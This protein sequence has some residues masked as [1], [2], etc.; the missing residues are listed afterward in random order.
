MD[1]EDANSGRYNTKKLIVENSTFW[2]LNKE[3]IS[4]YGGDS[5]AATQGPIININHCT[6]DSIGTDGTSV[7]KFEHVHV[8]EVL[9]SIISNSNFYSESISLYGSNSEISYSDT[10]KVGSFNLVNGAVAS[11]QILGEDPLYQPGPSGYYMLS[12]NSPLLG[13]AKDWK[14]MGDLRWDPTLTGVD[15]DGNKTIP[16]SFEL[17]QNYPNP[18]NPTTR[19]GFQLITGGE[20]S[21]K[22]YDVKGSLIKTIIEGFYSAGYHELVVNATGL[23][24]GIYFYKLQQ[25]VNYMVKKM[26]LLK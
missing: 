7:L 23:P 11:V 17:K 14:A 6:F 26:I 19:I 25:G 15:D 24:S 16:S 21:L 9:N 20:I 8:T 18:F 2:K 22:I 3:S 4:V 10:F 12:L 13:M 5:L 1:D